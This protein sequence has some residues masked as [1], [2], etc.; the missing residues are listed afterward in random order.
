VLGRN[1]TRYK[2]GSARICG[3]IS[4]HKFLYFKNDINGTLRERFELPWR[5]APPFFNTGAVA[6]LAP[7][8]RW[9]RV[10]VSRCPAQTRALVCGPGAG[11]LCL[12]AAGGCGGKTAGNGM[13][14]QGIR[15]RIAG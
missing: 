10:E 8:A 7:S 13:A 6:R 5:S 11:I 12:R 15:G 2:I 4:G 9:F 3:N 14:V 1:G